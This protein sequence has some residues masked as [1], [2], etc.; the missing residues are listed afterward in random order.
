MN[1]ISAMYVYGAGC[2]VA[3]FYLGTLWKASR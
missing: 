2:F 3:G 1:T